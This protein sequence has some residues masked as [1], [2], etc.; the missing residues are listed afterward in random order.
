MTVRL[1]FIE[2]RHI[3]LLG[4]VSKRFSLHLQSATA[5]SEVSA[6]K[7]WD[8]TTE[9]PSPLAEWHKYSIP[10]VIEPEDFLLE[11]PSRKTASIHLSIPRI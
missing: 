7:R 4:V 10:T 5:E 11:K 1:V 3:C 8:D 2:P 9:P 6:T